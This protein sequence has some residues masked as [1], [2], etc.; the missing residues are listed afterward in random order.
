[1]NVALEE[2]IKEELELGYTEGDI[3]LSTF[4]HDKDTEMTKF[5]GKWKVKTEESTLI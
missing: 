5:S 1:M 2:M 4:L 3:I